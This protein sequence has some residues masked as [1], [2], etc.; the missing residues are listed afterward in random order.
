ME[1]ILESNVGWR[2]GERAVPVDGWRLS[3]EGYGWFSLYRCEGEWDWKPS[4]LLLLLNMPG[5]KNRSDVNG[6][7]DDETADVDVVVWGVPGRCKMCTA[8]LCWM[9]RIFVVSLLIGCC[10]GRLSICS[11]RVGARTRADPSEFV[12]QCGL[13]WVND[14]FLVFDIE[15]QTGRR[16]L[17]ASS[18]AQ[19]ISPM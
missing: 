8:I 3:C 9:V 15:I 2:D 19:F 1:E 4:S 18:K 14:A 12:C 13:D 7:E 17:P 16:C 10:L 6:D 5:S 11:M